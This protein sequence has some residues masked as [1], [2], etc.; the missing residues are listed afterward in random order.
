[1]NYSLI[2]TLFGGATLDA[3]N[4]SA[5]ATTFLVLGTDNPK[6]LKA[7]FYTLGIYITNIAFGVVVLMGFHFYG[8]NLNFLSDFRTNMQSQ[9]FVEKSLSDLPLSYLLLFFFAQLK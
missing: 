5:I 7:V 4:P 9:S 6:N 1:L 2:A 3:I 8:I